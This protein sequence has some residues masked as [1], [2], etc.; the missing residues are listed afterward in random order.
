MISFIRNLGKKVEKTE[1]KGVKIKDTL[2]NKYFTFQ[3]L[4][5]ENNRVLTLMSEMEE[6]LAEEHL[7]DHD[8]VRDTTVAIVDGVHRLIDYIN[9]LSGN[10]YVELYKIHADISA[11][12]DKILTERT[13]IPVSDLVV[14]FAA[15]SK[16]MA[17]IAGHKIAQL[18]EIAKNLAL[19]TPEGFAISSYAFKRF[20]EHNLL[21]EK[22]AAHLAPV[23]FQ[24]LEELAPVSQKIQT[25]VRTADIPEELERA[26]AQAVAS[27]RSQVAEAQSSGPSAA[28]PFFVS[29]RSSALHEDGEFTFAGQYATFLNV[30]AEAIL[31]S[32]KAVIT[33]LFT[34]KALFYSKTKGFNE[35]DMVMAVGVMRMLPARAGGVMYTRD[36]NDR[37]N[38]AI[39]I[40][41][42]WGLGKGVVDGSTPH[43]FVVPRGEGMAI[44]RKIPIQKVMLVCKKEGDI[45][46]VEVPEADQGKACL[47]DAQIRL[48]ANYGA[49]LERH[50]GCPQDIEWATDIDDRIYILQSRP[51]PISAVVDQTAASIPGRLDNYPVLLEQGVIACKGISYGQAFVLKDEEELK[52]FPIGAVLVARNTDTKYVTIMP[53]A[54]AIITDVGG[55]AGHMASLTREYNVPAILDTGMATKVIKHGSWLTVDAVN[56]LVYAG[57]VEELLRWRA[58]QPSSGD[59]LFRDTRLYKTLEKVLTRIVPLH[60]VDPDSDSF[61]QE[62]CRT[63]HDITRFIHEKS[64]AEIIFMSGRTQEV[65]NFEDLMCAITFSETGDTRGLRDQTS[66]LYADIPMETHLLDIDRGLRRK[67]KKVALDDIASIPFHS[68]VKGLKD[69]RWPG[70]KPIAAQG[71]HG[72]LATSS[73][74]S[75]EPIEK[76]ISKSYAIISLNYMNFS[77]KLGYHFSMVEAYA[78][79]NM[80]DNYIKFF[81]KGGGASADRKL[82]RVRLITQIMKKMDFRVNVTEDVLNAMLTRYRLTDMETRLEIIGRLAAYTK[83]LDMVMFNDAVTDM[84]IDDFVRTYM[85]QI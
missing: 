9:S 1:I 23:D 57:R 45:E 39:I 20:M 78:S 47:S 76:V 13:V 60:L 10:R 71:I 67:G 31:E 62:S 41:A 29:V 54:A 81:F 73:V 83:Q 8:F 69:M 32:Y 33:S 35:A 37:N 64:M 48:L 74:K 55:V 82:R 7:F 24:N 50:Y 58:T 17:M 79:D 66:N 11:K 42:A 59:S 4:L 85:K 56:G 63:L 19:P 14:P 27:L 15:L 22:I 6:K 34:P 40:N 16:D 72:M 26:I 2:Q 18:G 75:G 12:I 70:A 5:A 68:F 77:L 52:D 80:N 46:E 36:P 3:K 25:L 38:D 49:A 21:S 30:P 53:K 28:S 51:L 43:S 65:K 61:R 84:F 44:G